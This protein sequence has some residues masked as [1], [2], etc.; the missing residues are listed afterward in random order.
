M[1]STIRRDDKVRKLA[2]LFVISGL[3]LIGCEKEIKNP[4]SP[5]PIE[6]ISPDPVPLSIK[7]FA[8]PAEGEAPLK[9]IFKTKTSG[10]KWPYQYFLVYGYGS[11]KP[12]WSNKDLT[13]AFYLWCSYDQPGIYTAVVTVTDGE[14]TEASDSVDI[15]VL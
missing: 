7:L 6:P 14:G 3:F 12:G 4:H 5:D 13:D 8:E 2:I 9:V 11:S 10:G 1:R 15:H